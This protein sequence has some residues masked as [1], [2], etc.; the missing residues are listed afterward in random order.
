MTFVL[1]NDERIDSPGIR[2]LHNALGKQRV[3]V[4][5]KEQHSDCGHLVTT[6]KPIHLKKRSECKYVVDVIHANYI[7]LSLT[8]LPK[9]CCQGS[10]SE[11]I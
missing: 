8:Q 11:Q 2:A 10:I 7:C 6:N 5:P 3:I 1:T 9:E 4:A